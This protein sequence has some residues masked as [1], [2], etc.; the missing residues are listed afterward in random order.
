MNLE[1]ENYVKLSDETKRVIEEESRRLEAADREKKA[2]AYFKCC[3]DHVFICP[4][5]G[6][7]LRFDRNLESMYLIRRNHKVHIFI[8]ADYESLH[9]GSLNEFMKKCVIH[10]RHIYI[11]IP[12]SSKEIKPIVQAAIDDSIQYKIFIEKDGKPR[13]FYCRTTLDYK[14]TEKCVMYDFRL[15]REYLVLT[16]IAY[17]N[18]Y[19]YE[20]KKVYG[21]HHIYEI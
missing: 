9:D 10:T 5:F 19:T 15:A 4:D 2:K 20:F 16:S 6:Y 11:H 3:M 12:F 7:I 18:R 1:I 21:G 13:I 14:V 8:S 17:F